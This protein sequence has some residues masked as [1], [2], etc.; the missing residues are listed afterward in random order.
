MSVSELVEGFS[1][2][3]LEFSEKHNGG[4]RNYPFAFGAFTVD[5]I[6][7]FKELGLT[8]AQLNVLKERLERRRDWNQ[9]N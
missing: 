5:M 8:E 9:L 2:L 7:T 4:E 6:N 1:Q 3:A